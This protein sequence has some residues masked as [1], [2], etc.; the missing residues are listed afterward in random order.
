[1]A[2]DETAL[3]GNAAGGVLDSLFG[4]E[5][6]AA[7]LACAHC[8]DVNEVAR[9]ILYARAPG[10]VLRCPSCTSVMVRVV[11]APG[12]TLIDIATKAPVDTPE[13]AP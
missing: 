13:T 6:T 8:G 2:I 3:D 4:A 1:M 11:Q 12:R 10:L 7:T 9:L 5:L